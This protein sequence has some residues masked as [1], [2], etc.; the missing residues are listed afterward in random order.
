MKIRNKITLWITGAGMVAGLLFS[1]V[2]SF[3]MIEQPYELLDAELRSQAQ[4]L[5]LGL[6]PVNGKLDRLPKNSMLESIGKLYWF[7]LYNQQRKLL[8]GSK[9][10]QFV[11]LP[12]RNKKN[13]YNVNAETPRNAANIAQDDS[14]HI[15]FRA[16]VF[17]LPYHGHN[18]LIQIARPMEKLEE[19]FTDL[20][21][22]I[23]IGLFVFAGA[24]IPL[25]Y[26]VAGKILQPIASINSLAKEISEKTLDKRIP[27]GNNHD[28]IHSLSSSLNGMFDR[29]QFSFQ[30]QKE[31]LANASHEL[32]TPL[33][34]QR[35]FFD[36]AWLREDLPEDFQE[37]IDGQIKICYRMDRLVKNLLDLSALEL[38]DSFQ[39]GTVDLTTMVYSVLQDFKE[40]MTAPALHLT[41]DIQPDIQ[42]QADREKLRRVLINIIDNA[43]KYNTKQNPEIHFLL[44]KKINQISIEVY[45]T[46]QG[47]P[48]D[49]LSCI[50]DQFYRV[51][52]SRAVNLGG[53]GLGLTIVKR[54]IELH[55]G[56]IDI[57]SKTD[58]GVWVRILL[59]IDRAFSS[60]RQQQKQS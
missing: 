12:L 37:Q 9:M 32:K 1:L 47:I 43:I 5:F 33:A 38:K 23:P 40:M 3:E 7:K 16:H 14:N 44:R 45:N 10:T 2:V 31:F 56:K 8:F 52:K 20:A 48:P 53:S 6:A 24:L 35:L 25:A 39:L 13:G 50:F 36:E 15:T 57:E 59:P 46:C 22:A 49:D 29:L 58:H 60:P 34:M 42:L 41:T 54:I 18:Y 4:T 21:I 27:L 51:E 19:E 55:D 28:E 30:Q 17:T 26:L 11:D